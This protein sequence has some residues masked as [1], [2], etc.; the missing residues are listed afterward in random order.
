VHGQRPEACRVYDCR[1]DKRIWK[2][3]EKRI[4]AD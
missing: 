2:D 3:F 1:N 4:L